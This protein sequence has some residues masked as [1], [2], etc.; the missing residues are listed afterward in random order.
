MKAPSAATHVPS[1]NVPRT[2]CPA[3][4]GQKERI[5]SFASDDGSADAAD[6]SF[7]TDAGHHPHVQSQEARH[8]EH[9]GSPRAR[10]VGA[11]RTLSVG[12]GSGSARSDVSST[13][14]SMD[15]GVSSGV[16]WR[17]QAHGPRARRRARR[18]SLGSDRVPS[19]TSVASSMWSEDSDADVDDPPH[20][21]PM[22]A[23]EGA[24]DAQTSV[25]AAIYSSSREE[26]NRQY[27]QILTR[28]K[29]C[30]K[31]LRSAL[32]RTHG[33]GGNLSSAS[34]LI[35]P[36]RSRPRVNTFVVLMLF[37]SDCVE[38]TSRH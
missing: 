24:A 18:G 11:G 25:P 27:L 15:D 23:V 16:L 37:A 14:G 36:V 7:R 32:R 21:M 13:F 26:H 31:K 29:L 3:P 20:P 17:R 10:H 1:R 19:G 5:V 34:R 33:A 35:K 2:R 8:D 9:G 6:H 4:K 30:D 22:C 38:V 28:L 12:G